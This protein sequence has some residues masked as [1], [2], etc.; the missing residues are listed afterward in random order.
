MRQKLE[1][2]S[3]PAAIS[4]PIG[5]GCMGLQMYLL[6]CERYTVPIIEFA[7][8][9]TQQIKCNNSEPLANIFSIVEREILHDFLSQMIPE[10]LHVPYS[11]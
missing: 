9:Q 11:V 7:N 1:C 8:S 6:R 5:K 3:N 2:R 10:I 4:L